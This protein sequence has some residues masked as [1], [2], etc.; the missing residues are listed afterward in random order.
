MIDNALSLGAKHEPREQARVL[1]AVLERIGPELD[2]GAI[3]VVLPQ[4]LRIR[5]LPI[6]G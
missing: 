2:A 1:I 4:A 3:V 6:G 5:R